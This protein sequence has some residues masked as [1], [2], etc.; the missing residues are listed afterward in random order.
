MLIERL[1]KPLEIPFSR[2]GS[3]YSNMINIITKIAVNVKP[4]RHARTASG[5][6]YKKELVSVGICQNKSHPFQALYSKHEDAI[7]LHSETD[8]IKNALKEL[9]LEEISKC[10]MCICRVK[11]TDA[12]KKKQIFGH[13][14][15]C[16]GCMK[17]IV[18]FNISNI[19][20]SLDEEGY[21]V[22]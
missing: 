16:I 8:C 6:F 3:K 13:S 1:N 15:P 5:L 22:I 18:T 11:Y 17:A 14:K 4:V 9:S 10:T 2:G 21:N 7:F 19:V 12:K 20:Y